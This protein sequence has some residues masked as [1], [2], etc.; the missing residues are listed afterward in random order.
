MSTITPQELL[1]RWKLEQIPVEMAM[2]HV[3]QNLV[4]QQTLIDS[5]TLALNKL[6]LQLDN[7]PP[8]VGALSVTK[9]KQKTR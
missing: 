6:R 1:K 2:G 8:P 7:T 4:Q 3:L 5:L 9:D